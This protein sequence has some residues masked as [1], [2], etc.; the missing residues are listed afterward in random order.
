MLNFFAALNF[1]LNMKYNKKMQ[2]FQEK[3]KFNNNLK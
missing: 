3:I 2:I 1:I